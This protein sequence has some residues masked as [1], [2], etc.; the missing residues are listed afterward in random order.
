MDSGRSTRWHRAVRRLRRSGA[1]LLAAGTFLGAAPAAAQQCG[2]AWT[3]PVVCS[4]TLLGRTGRE[5]WRTYRRGERIRIP[6]G[7][8]LDLRIRAWDQNGRPFPDERLRF[9]IDIDPSCGDRLRLERL[10][11]G[12]WRVAAGARHGRCRAVAWIPGNLNLDFPVTFEVTPLAAAGYT[13]AQARFIARA[14]YL[15]IL[16][17]EPDP[18]GWEAATAEIQRGRLAAE[19]RAMLASSEF[20]ARARRLSPSEL[21][22]GYYA[23]LL[24]RPP[25]SEGVRT[26]LR[27]VERGRSADVILRMVRSEEFERRL[28]ARSGPGARARRLLRR[29]R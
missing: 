29:N 16:G 26:Y 8:S 1:W 27:R 3:R 23:G 11:G 10:A 22:D 12:G 21:L 9:G 15:A 25:D 13:R 5:R 18:A 14:L 2:E 19:V 17:R 28:L 4:F 20:R 24:G 6:A 7:T